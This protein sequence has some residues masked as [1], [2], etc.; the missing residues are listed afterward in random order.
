ML[1]VGAGLGYHWGEWTPGPG[2][3][4]TRPPRLGGRS[5]GSYHAHAK[6]SSSSANASRTTSRYCMGG[7]DQEMPVGQS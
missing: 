1:R 4:A 2:K 3:H 7:W 5:L 6:E